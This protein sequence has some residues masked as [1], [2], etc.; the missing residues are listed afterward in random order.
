MRTAKSSGQKIGLHFCQQHTLALNVR[1]T[2]NQKTPCIVR[3]TYMEVLKIVRENMH[4]CA[5]KLRRQAVK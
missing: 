1:V 2:H 4:V 5:E 3:T